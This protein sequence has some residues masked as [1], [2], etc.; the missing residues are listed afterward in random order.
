MPLR[1]FSLV[2]RD[3]V[4]RYERQSRRRVE[5]EAQTFLLRHAEPEIDEIDRRLD[6]KLLTR[7][8]LVEGIIKLLESAENNEPRMHFGIPEFNERGF[9]SRGP[10]FRSVGQDDVQRAMQKDCPV[11]PYC[12]DARSCPH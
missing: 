10:D 12:P 11:F 1:Q 6:S 7:E 5:P 9:G 2:V 3:A 4:R 8:A